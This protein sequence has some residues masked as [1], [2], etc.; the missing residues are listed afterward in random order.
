MAAKV[1]FDR[2][3]WWVFIYHQGKRKKR[4]IGPL[5]SDRRQ[6]E[7]IARKVNGALALG[8]FTTGD[9]DP[10]PLP[11]DGELRRWHATYAVT[12]K[13][14]YQALTSGLIE[15]H[16]APHFGSRDIRE[17]RDADLL[18][19]IRAKLA[20]GL[21]PR[22][23]RNGLSVLRRV[24]TLLEREELISTI[25]HLLASKPDV[26]RTEEPSISRINWVGPERRTIQDPD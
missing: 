18:D 15:N 5:K 9:N 14:T 20:S 24:F 2:G 11:C 4:R 7:E 25:Q 8:T 26:T 1:K 21:S 6:A 10:R 16:L 12:M 3:A 17:I 19:Y 22:T 23:I 13:P